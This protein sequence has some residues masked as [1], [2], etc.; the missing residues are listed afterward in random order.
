[1]VSEFMEHRLSHPTCKIVG[2]FG[3]ITMRNSKDRDLI[4]HRRGVQRRLFGDWNT[5]VEAQEI[6][7]VGRMFLND[8]HQ[9]FESRPKLL[10]HLV[11]NDGHEFLKL[12]FGHMMGHS[13]DPREVLTPPC[14]TLPSIDELGC[15]TTCSHS[16]TNRPRSSKN[17]T[18]QS[19]I[20]LH[21]LPHLIDSIGLCLN[22]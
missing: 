5:F 12:L 6:L 16:P 2:I 21:Q 17:A 14:I 9:V 8:H 10:G 13:H 11:K 1:M 7:S 15:S 22:D 19:G 4:R 3:D 20:A 18:S